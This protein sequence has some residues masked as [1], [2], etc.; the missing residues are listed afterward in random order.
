MIAAEAVSEVYRL[1]IS[2]PPPI[3]HANLKVLMNSFDDS[4]DNDDQDEVKCSFCFV[5]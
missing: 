2:H 4:D 3:S 5:C 1:Y